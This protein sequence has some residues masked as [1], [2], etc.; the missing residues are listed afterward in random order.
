MKTKFLAFLLMP[1]LLSSCSHGYSGA[2]YEI[3]RSSQ[4]AL[5]QIDASTLY[6]KTITNSEA[7]VVL[8]SQQNCAACTSAKEDIE[9]YCLLESVVMYNVDLS[10]V[11]KD[12]YDIIR[13]TTNYYS[14]L[15][16]LPEF[17]EDLLLPIVYFYLE[18]SV[19]YT[20]DNNFVDFFVN[21]I[22]I[23]EPSD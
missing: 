15:Y 12:D 11:G 1:C 7:I 4:G 5:V 23:V 22:K 6:E 18:Q 9:S 14:E 19:V 3:V 20:V 16:A 21:R 2:R 8:F 13:S 10:S 17:G